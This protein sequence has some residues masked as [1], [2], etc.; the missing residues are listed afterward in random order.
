MKKSLLWMIALILLLAAF[1][2]IAEDAYEAAAMLSAYTGNEEIATVPA[3]LQGLPVT[4]IGDGCFAET[5]VHDLTLPD[6][7]TSIGEYAFW[8]CPLEAI[9]G[10]E[11]ILHLGDGAFF[12]T[13][14]AEPVLPEGLLS[15]GDAAFQNCDSITEIT[16]WPLW[17]VPDGTFFECLGLMRVILPDTVEMLGAGAFYGCTALCD[18]SLGEGLRAIGESAFEGCSALEEI[19]LPE[20]LETLGGSAFMD[21]GALR[22]CRL[23][24]SLAYIGEDAF[25]QCPNLCLVV[26]KDSYAE[27]Y[28]IENEL[29]FLHE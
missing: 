20:G 12:G 19:T 18:I 8:L 15:M 1:H 27:R 26:S 6:T 5:G 11:N 17:R 21:C 16:S 13:H 29:A 2:G 24:A 3:E 10:T 4:A 9:H 14:I 23:P 7:V 28:A 25:A 22:I